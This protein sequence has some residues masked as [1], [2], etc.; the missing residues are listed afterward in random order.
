[1][2]SETKNVFIRDEY[3]ILTNKLK[4]NEKDYQNINYWIN[5]ILWMY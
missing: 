2:L 4:N 1:M 5:S 3:C